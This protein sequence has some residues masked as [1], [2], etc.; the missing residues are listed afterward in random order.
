MQNNMDCQTELVGKQNHT[1][2]LKKTTAVSYKVKYSLTM[3]PS[4]SIPRF[5]PKEIKTY[6]HTKTCI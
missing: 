6:V 3:Q 1:T 5:F 4:N 2:T